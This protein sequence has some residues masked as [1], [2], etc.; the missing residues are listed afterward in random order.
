MGK[1]FLGLPYQN[2]DFII[3]IKNRR[4][5]HLTTRVSY[6]RTMFFL[7][8]SVTWIFEYSTDETLNMLNVA[9]A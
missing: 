9:L 5:A 4:N 8:S 1:C 2:K 6:L 3:I 7:F